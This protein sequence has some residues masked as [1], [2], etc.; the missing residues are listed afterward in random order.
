MVRARAARARAHEARPPPASVPRQVHP[1]ARRGTARAIRT[2]G[3]AVLDPFAGSGTTLVQALESGRDAVGG[4]IAAFNC[5]LMRV[6]TA[7][8]NEFTLEK[9]LRDACARLDR[10]VQVPDPGS[11]SVTDPHISPSGSRRRR[12]RS[13][14][15]GA[16]SST[17]TSTSTSCGSSSPARPGRPGSRRTSTSTSRGCRSE[18]RTGATSTSASAVP[19]SPPHS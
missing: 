10:H 8:Y 14:S 15:T 19:V 5:L 18:S 2:A 3:R 1:A 16:R 4:D 7:R 11:D 9:E 6:K 17:T 12:R 13:C